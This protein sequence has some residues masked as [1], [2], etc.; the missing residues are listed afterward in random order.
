MSWHVDICELYTDIFA[1]GPKQPN[2]HVHILVI[3]S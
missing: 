1:N 2:I 3:K